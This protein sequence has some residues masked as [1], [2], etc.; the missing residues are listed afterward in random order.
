M[1]TVTR[2]RGEMFAVNVSAGKSFCFVRESKSGKECFLHAS[3]LFG[4]K[5]RMCEGGIVEF[6]VD[7]SNT[8]P[9]PLAKNAVLIK[10]QPV[11]GN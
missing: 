10:L 2:I 9:R 5:A 4:G 8:G 11:E 7:D 3:D 6:D 1:D